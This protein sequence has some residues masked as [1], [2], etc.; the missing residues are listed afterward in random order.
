MMRLN[1]FLWRIAL[2]LRILVLITIIVGIILSSKYLKVIS[3]L[4]SV[5]KCCQT[6]IQYFE[7]CWQLVIR[8]VVSYSLNAICILH[9]KEITFIYSY[10]NKTLKD[11]IC[12][13][14]YLKLR[15][16]FCF[17]IITMPNFDRYPIVWNV[18]VI[19]ILP[20]LTEAQ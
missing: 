19:C 6:L 18:Q 9:A 8:N 12:K 5:E 15:F 11:G 4:I 13:R 20:M 2:S 1:C 14:K 3:W 10:I 7:K 16:L 17:F